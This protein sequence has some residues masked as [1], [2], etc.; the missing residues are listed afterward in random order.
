MHHLRAVLC[1]ASLL[2]ASVA[3]T[4]VHAQDGDR[5]RP[6]VQVVTY[7]RDDGGYNE[8]LGWGS[9]S[10]VDDHGL[11]VSN[12]HVVTLENQTT[13]ADAI[14]ICVTTSRETR[15][16][17]RYT[18]HVLA[19][20]PVKDISV[21]RIDSTDIFGEEV[22]FSRFATLSIASEDELP[23]NQS[24]VTAVGYP[25]IGADTMSET[26]GVVSGTIEYNGATYLKSDA[27]IA[28][29]NS[30]GALIDSDG[31]LV[32]IPTF[33][34]GDDTSLGYALWIGEARDFIR[35]SSR[36]ELLTDPDEDR[37]F[38]ENRR[39]IETANDEGRIDDAFVSISYSSN[40]ELRGYLERSRL[41]IVSTGK[42]EFDL[43]DVNVDF[44]S[45]PKTDE[46]G[47]LY[48][49][50]SQSFFDRA[51]SK[52]K[53]RTLGDK[54]LYEILPKSG[55]DYSGQRIL[56]GRINDRTAAIISLQ[57]PFYDTDRAPAYRAEY[58][59][60]LAGIE[61]H[62]SSQYV[63][64][65]TVPGLGLRVQPSGSIAY[66]NY[67]GFL[68]VFLGNFHELFNFSTMKFDLSS[69]S[70][71]ETFEEFARDRESNSYSGRP[72]RLSLGGIDGLVTCGEASYGTTRKDEHGADL[73]EMGSCNLELYRVEGPDGSAH[74]VSVS[75]VS[76]RANLGRNLDRTYAA[77]A[78][79]L[80]RS[81]DVSSIAN[82]AREQEVYSDIAD[83][84]LGFKKRVAWLVEHD[85]LPKKSLLKP[86]QAVTWGEFL[87]MYLRFMY[88][89]KYDSTAAKCAERDYACLFATVK[90]ASVYP[91]R[92][93]EMGNSKTTFHDVFMSLGIEYSQPLA[94]YIDS[95]FE[96]VMLLEI[97][98]VD[99]SKMSFQSV[100]DLWQET[101]ESVRLTKLA[102][103]AQKAIYRGD[104]VTDY[105]VFD[106]SG[107]FTQKCSPYRNSAGLIRLQCSSDNDQKI[108]FNATR[109]NKENF[110]ALEG[111]KSR[112]AILNSAACTPGSGSY[113]ADACLAAL[114]AEDR[115]T[116]AQSVADSDMEFLMSRAAAISWLLGSMDF[117]L[118]DHS[119]ARDKFESDDEDDSEATDGR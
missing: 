66:N 22:D 6:V 2:V 86:D 9:A 79:M 45:I 103:S 19:T 93:P 73:P 34:I 20:D 1:I 65:Y 13:L 83:L 18:A 70:G 102:E 68:T 107:Y 53:K 50:E 60:F 37:A 88:A 40:Y 10:V 69:N 39:A 5:Y 113:S 17:C 105:S 52:L 11:L 80:G 84:P 49:M 42:N 116:V 118:F 90:L 33:T 117:S 89:V 72:T 44:M 24:S 7:S 76:E 91:E 30:G 31:E 95:S 27:V 110:K 75:L 77:V 85:L 119:L 59:R 26:S 43:A 51:Y 74:A 23:A 94:S 82:P 106:E 54:V 71:W 63:P 35:E 61:F 47:F 96:S 38:R 92:T 108:D 15:P 115:V 97:A 41:Q 21:L 12:N 28:G 8:M 62:A 48:L 56:I 3:T 81:V 64:P 101:P 14:A 57:A 4:L 36:S 29:G 58:E 46:A 114:N 78:R 98:G 100:W 32:G 67:H 99:T 112:L 87:D 55:P 104:K 109:I 25:W 16:D 111:Y